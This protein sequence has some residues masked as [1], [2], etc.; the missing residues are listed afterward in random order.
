MVEDMYGQIVSRHMN[1]DHLSPDFGN[2]NNTEVTQDLGYFENLLRQE[3]DYELNYEIV[4]QIEDR[5]R[6]LIGRAASRFVLPDTDEVIAASAR[7]NREAEL[8]LDVKEKAACEAMDE[9][10][11]FQKDAG[12]VGVFGR[13]ESR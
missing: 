1:T 6:I 5:H 3:N 9:F 11:S 12:I 2:T 10:D 4:E 13:I 8:I 7:F